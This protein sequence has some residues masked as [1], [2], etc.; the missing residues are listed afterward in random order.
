MSE[1][2][3]SLQSTESYYHGGRG[4][5]SL[6]NPP[7][8]FELPVGFLLKQVQGAPARCFGHIYSLYVLLTVVISFTILLLNI[9]ERTAQPSTF[10]RRV[11]SDITM[12]GCYY[13]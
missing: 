11:V 7:M 4:T 2:I 9:S 8:S 10:K 6:L 3:G 12:L 1:T 5:H 13:L